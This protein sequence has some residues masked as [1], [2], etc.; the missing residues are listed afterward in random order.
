MNKLS[1]KELLK[2]VE[3]ICLC[4]YNSEEECQ[5]LLDQVRNNVLM[6]DIS[7]LIFKHDPELTPEEIVAKALS[8]KPIITPPPKKTD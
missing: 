4:N 6:P 7:D 5:E 8:Y 1:R 3:N 2:L